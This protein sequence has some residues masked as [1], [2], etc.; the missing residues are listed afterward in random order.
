MPGAAAPQRA[1]RTAVC[2]AVEQAG[3]HETRDGSGAAR[4]RPPGAPLYALA[5][6]A[7]LLT[8]QLLLEAATALRP[9][10]LNTAPVPRHRAPSSR[11]TLMEAAAEAPA[12][13]LRARA[14]CGV[15]A[16][17]TAASGRWR[18]AA[19]RWGWEP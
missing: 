16:G 15:G 11:A 4:N 19:R 13:R 7:Q 18:R 2:A 6:A 1:G 17:P 10:T 12:L 8:P 5:D 9:A 14:P 3:K